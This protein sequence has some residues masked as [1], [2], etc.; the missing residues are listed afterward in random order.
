MLIFLPAIL[1]LGCASSSPAFHMM[2]SACKLNKQGDNIQSCHV[3]FPILN[4]FVFP[5]LFLTVA[6]CPACKFLS[7][8]VSCGIPNSLR[9]FHCLLVA[10]IVKNLP[11]KWETWVQ[12]LHQEDPLEK[13]LAAHPSILAWRIPWTRSLVGYIPRGPKELDMTESLTHT[14]KGCNVVNEAE[15]DFFFFNSLAFWFHVI[16]AGKEQTGGLCI[17]F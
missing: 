17:D 1:I 2:Y 9:I 11:A 5:C 6:S 10:H 8:Q 7:R 4:Q 13:E 15:V 16:A 14:H 3:P 12:S